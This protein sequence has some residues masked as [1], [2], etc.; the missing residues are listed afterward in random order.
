MDNLY[1]YN[2]YY[3]FYVSTK[4]IEIIKKLCILVKIL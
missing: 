2:I 4:F 3:L 1:N